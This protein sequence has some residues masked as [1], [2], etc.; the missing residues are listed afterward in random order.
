MISS[1]EGEVEREE[2][3][4]GER[5]GKRLLGKGVRTCGGRGEEEGRG[6]R[7]KALSET[8]EPS[9]FQSAWLLLC[10]LALLVLLS[11]S[12]FAFVMLRLEVQWRAREKGRWRRSN[13]KAGMRKRG[14]IGKEVEDR[15][16]R[17]ATK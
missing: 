5:Q 14:R 2:E 9:S 4:E 10:P 8:I 1:A 3:R 11:L 6:R 13:L 17:R 12:R 15:E 7:P 16:Q